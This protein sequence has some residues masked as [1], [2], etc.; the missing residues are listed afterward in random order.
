MPKLHIVVVE[1]DKLFLLDC[2]ATYSPRWGGGGIA[3]NILH[4]TVR[5]VPDKLEPIS[6]E[7]FFISRGATC[8]PAYVFKNKSYIQWRSYFGAR[9]GTG[10]L[11]GSFGL[12]PGHAPLPSFWRAHISLLALSYGARNDFPCI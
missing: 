7:N 10:T 4:K 2:L 5:M 12:G 11:H 1:I 3:K 6:P 8:C 9:G